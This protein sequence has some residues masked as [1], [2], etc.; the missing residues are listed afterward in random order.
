MAQI[1]LFIFAFAC[2][3]LVQCKHSAKMNTPPPS[4]QNQAIIKRLPAQYIDDGLDYEQM[5]QPSPDDLS[6]AELKAILYRKKFSTIEQLLKYLQEIKPKYMAKYTLGFDSR[7]LHGSSKSH[8]RAIVYGLKANF[9]ITFNGDPRHEGYE[10]LETVEFNHKRKTFEF[11][12][13]EFKE[14]RPTN[15]PFKIS[16][17]G[18]P[19]IS[20]D[21][22]KCTQCHTNNRPIWDR[23]DLWPGFYGGID[24]FPFVIS[25][26]TNGKPNRLDTGVQE[27]I[28]NDYQLFVKQHST[29]GRYRF[30]NPLTAPD[31]PGLKNYL[32][33]LRPNSELT[34]KLTELN[35]QRIAKLLQNAGGRGK[36]KY[37]LI[38]ALDCQPLLESQQN[39]QHPV[40]EKIRQLTAE[41]APQVF[42]NLV[43]YE[44]DRLMRLAEDYNT[45]VEKLTV[46]PGEGVNQ[47]S[48]PSHNSYEDN[49]PILAITYKF[50]PKAQPATWSMAVYEDVQGYNS[51]LGG[52]TNARL[53]SV[54]REK[55][56]SQAEKRFLGA[57]AN[58]GFD[59][60]DERLQYC[61]KLEQRF[62][63]ELR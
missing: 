7:S 24:D 58:F 56:L 47:L 49:L 19:K 3:L 9:I 32:N 6:F 59:L 16:E 14:S 29:R 21:Q 22:R 35:N 20:K 36:Y 30:L 57:P 28:M 27:T 10:M 31:F 17:I 26:S 11:R 43:N 18:G 15:T 13:I 61:K 63:A 23:Y 12:E 5:T 37:P 42:R 50:L 25:N 52:V 39:T 34:M 55:L 45:S 53:A 62:P 54:I 44:K 38:Y 41:L 51:F 4:P 2:L 46:H 48:G 40:N 60:T 1:K 8:P 33:E